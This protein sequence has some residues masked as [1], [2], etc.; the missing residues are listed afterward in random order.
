MI[1]LT[2]KEQKRI[3]EIRDCLDKFRNFGIDLST[4]ESEFLL[5]VIDRLTNTRRT[6]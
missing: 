1:R 3:K 2:R 4:W 6:K 5:G